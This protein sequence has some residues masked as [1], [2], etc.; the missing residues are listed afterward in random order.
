[1]QNPWMHLFPKSMI[2]MHWI[3]YL[4]K[5]MNISLVIQSEVNFL[6]INDK[7]VRASN[8]H[9]QVPGLSTCA[10]RSVL[11]VKIQY[12]CSLGKV[13]FLWFGIYYSLRKKCCFP[14]TYH[15]SYL[16]FQKLSDTSSASKP[17][18]LWVQASAGTSIWWLT[19]QSV[20]LKHNGDPSGW[21]L[22]IIHCA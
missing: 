3:S 6:L 2:N 9:F 13:L 15:L 20:W 18:R 19:G 1:M 4:H 21:L 11:R 17:C 14:I 10:L 16:N 8:E 12:S 5:A 7:C 22:C